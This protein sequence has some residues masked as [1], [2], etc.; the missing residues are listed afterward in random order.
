MCE[1]IGQFG[2]GLVPPSQDAMRGKLL[3]EE[4]ERTKSELQCMLWSYELQCCP[5][6]INCV[7]HFLLMSYPLLLKLP[8]ADMVCSWMGRC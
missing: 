6:F 5:L 2:P 7:V 3:E 4:Y 1:A 8:A